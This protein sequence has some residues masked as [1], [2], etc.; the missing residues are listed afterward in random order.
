MK[1]LFILSVI[2]WKKWCQKTR[3][4]KTVV[5]EIKC[6]AEIYLYYISIIFF[7]HLH[8]C[9]MLFTTICYLPSRAQK[10]CLSS[11]SLLFVGCSARTENAMQPMICVSLILPLYR[12][13]NY[14]CVSGLTNLVVAFEDC[15]KCVKNTIANAD[16]LL[17]LI[18]SLMFISRLLC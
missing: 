2:I 18:P 9:N 10:V 3:R 17:F 4:Q 11:S 1:G 8:L 7:L 14:L 16:V 13:V 5:C 12:G 6:F 15:T